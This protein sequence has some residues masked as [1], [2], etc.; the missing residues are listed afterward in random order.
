MNRGGMNQ[1]QQV[2][3]DE[4][5]PMENFGFQSLPSN[6]SRIL[7]KKKIDINFFFFFLLFLQRGILLRPPQ[8]H[9]VPTQ[10]INSTFRGESLPPTMM[11]PKMSSAEEKEKVGRESQ[12]QEVEED[13]APKSSP[14]RE[15]EGGGDSAT[16]CSDPNAELSENGRQSI[17]GSLERDSAEK[18]EQDGNGSQDDNRRGEEQKKAESANRRRFSLSFERMNQEAVNARRRLSLGDT[19]LNMKKIKEEPIFGRSVSTSAS[20]SSTVIHNA[21]GGEL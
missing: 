1:R 21:N 16:S 10:H 4:K 2:L 15:E 13:A 17:S 20:S 18:E 11:G 14:N 3:P 19:N 9:P 8:T 6:V 7:L 5:Y 12:Q